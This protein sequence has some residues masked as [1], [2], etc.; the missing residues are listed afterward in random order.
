[1]PGTAKIKAFYQHPLR[2]SAAPQTFIAIAKGEL[3]KK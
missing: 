3:A 2:H 1:M